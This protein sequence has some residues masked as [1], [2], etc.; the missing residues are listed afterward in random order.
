MAKDEKILQGLVKNLSEHRRLKTITDA[1]E[2]DLKL[3]D[4]RVVMENTDDDSKPT[5]VHAYIDEDYRK[6]A[7][8]T[9]ISAKKKIFREKRQVFEDRRRAKSLERQ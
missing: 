7:L 6:K 9:S 4:P 1:L 5:I 3:D 8:A 2:A